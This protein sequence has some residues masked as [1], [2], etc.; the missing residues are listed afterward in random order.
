MNTAFYQEN[1][2]SNANAQQTVPVRRCGR[3][4]L[5]LSAVGLGLAGLGVAGREIDAEDERAAFVLLDRAAELGVTHWDTASGYTGGNSERLVGR[6]FAARGHDARDRVIL[7]TKWHSPLGGGRGMIRKAVDG[8]LRRLQTDYIDLFMLHNPMVEGGRYI[9]PLAETWGTLND[10]VTQGKVHYLGISNA[11]GINVRDAQAALE[12]TQPGASKRLVAVENHYN[13][14]RPYVAGWGLWT[15]WAR[16]SVHREFLDLLAGQGMG[17]VPFWP[18]ADG[19]LTGRYRN[20]NRDQ[21]LAQLRPM[22]AKE[23]FEGPNAD[24]IESLAQFADAKNITLGQLG[25]AWLLAQNVVPSVIVGT[26]NIKHL[27]TNAAAAATLTLSPDDLQQIDTLAAQAEPLEDTCFRLF[28][29]RP[30]TPRSK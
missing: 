15:D 20:A 21:W 27:E 2:V 8:C 1:N 24:V 30:V 7:S 3:S 22:F 18:L 10:L 28:G 17:L 16:G 29:D 13:M 6:W 26:T 14:L 5:C 19:A 12:Q 25:I 23:Y 4:G 11:H 9:A